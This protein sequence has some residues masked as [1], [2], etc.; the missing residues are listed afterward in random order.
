[1]SSP[2][3][4]ALSCTSRNQSGAS[5]TSALTLCLQFAPKRTWVDVVDECTSAV[6][7]DHRKPFAIARFEV[8][9]A[10]DVDLVERRAA[11][12]EHRPRAVAEVRSEEHTSELQS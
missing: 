9:V 2:C 3:N 4:S 1:M 5:V 6:D 8:G 11:R 10:G 7:L 12:L